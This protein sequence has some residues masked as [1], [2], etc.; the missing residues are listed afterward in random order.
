MNH[1]YQGQIANK[2][3]F[4]EKSNGVPAIYEMFQSNKIGISHP[5]PNI[6]RIF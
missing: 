4:S 6:G 2:L 5:P 1:R 3:V